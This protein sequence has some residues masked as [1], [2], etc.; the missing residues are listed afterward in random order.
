MDAEV[1][2]R[3]W[4]EASEVNRTRGVGENLEE[5]LVFLRFT[6]DLARAF[7]PHRR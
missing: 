3:A 1:N 2:R 5:L 6:E 4:R 7:A